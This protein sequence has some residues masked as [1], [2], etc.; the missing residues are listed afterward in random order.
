MGV[1][2][3]GGRQSDPVQSQTYL[4]VGCGFSHASLAHQSALLCPSGRTL[5]TVYQ[6]RA[7]GPSSHWGKDLGWGAQPKPKPECSP[8]SCLAPKSFL[9]NWPQ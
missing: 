1:S 8:H 9:E 6:D 7:L 2:E 3:C 5:G 4:S